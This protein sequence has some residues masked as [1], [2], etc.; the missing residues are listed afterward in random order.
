MGA[1]QIMAS[2]S[3]EIAEIQQQMHQVRKR[4]GVDVHDLVENA[5]ALTDWRRYWR[6]HP[7]AWCGAAAVLGYCLVPSRRFEDSDSQRLADL[8][9]AS[10]GKSPAPRRNPIISELA[11]MALGIL[12]Q[13]GK[14][15]VAQ[16]VARVFESRNANQVP[17]HST[18]R[19]DQ[20]RS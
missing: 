20:D 7:W 11:G 1:R 2:A 4:A 6:R 8:L 9:Q 13:Q 18:S 3:T 14:Q 17:P 5:R 10:R 19:S 12:M 16:H 15:L